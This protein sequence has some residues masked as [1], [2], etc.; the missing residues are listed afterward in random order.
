MNLRRCSVEPSVV[1]FGD[2]CPGTPKYLEV[3]FQCLK[4]E[5]QERRWEPRFKDQKIREVWDPREKFLSEEAVR[6]SLN[7]EMNHRINISDVEKDA[8]ND[9]NEY[10]KVDLLGLFNRLNNSSELNVSIIDNASQLTSETK[11]T[12]SIDKSHILAIQQ[13]PFSGEVL[14]SKKMIVII[15]IGS[16]SVVLCIIILSYC[17]CKLKKVLNSNLNVSN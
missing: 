17:T 8:L 13:K 9:T 1:L 10:H 4:V 15:L 7:V 3:Q 12:A 2:S 6:S 16:S 5:E 11:Q 14:N